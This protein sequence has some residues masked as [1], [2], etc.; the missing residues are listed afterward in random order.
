MFTAQAVIWIRVRLAET[1]IGNATPC[2][3]TFS[4]V[5]PCIVILRFNFISSRKIWIFIPVDFAKEGNVIQN[6]CSTLA[7]SM[8]K[9]RDEASFDRKEKLPP[10]C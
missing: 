10:I 2:I 3:A 7:Q 1:P 9:Q 5:T 8:A 6:Y 4:I